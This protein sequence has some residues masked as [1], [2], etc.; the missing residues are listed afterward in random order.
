MRVTGRKYLTSA[1]KYEQYSPSWQTM[2]TSFHP[3]TTL[4]LLLLPERGRVFFVCPPS[5]GALMDDH[6]IDP[7]SYDGATRIAQT[8]KAYWFNRG[9]TNIH[10]NV[11]RVLIP[12]KDMRHA[13]YGVVSNIGP[14]G[15]PPS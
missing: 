7:C 14:S 9:Y 2:S 11:L 10:T 3:P 8:I 1:Q 4:T 12:G 6:K 13:V 15:F 5:S